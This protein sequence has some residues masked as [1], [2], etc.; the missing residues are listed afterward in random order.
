MTWRGI[1]K[2]LSYWNLTVFG[3]GKAKELNLVGFNSGFNSIKNT[4]L[5][6]RCDTQA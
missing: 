2:S 5:I 1:E 6:L 4:Q 3:S